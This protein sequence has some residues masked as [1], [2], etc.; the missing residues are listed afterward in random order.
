MRTGLQTHKRV[1]FRETLP[2]F[3]FAL[4]LAVTWYTTWHVTAAI[5]DGDTSSELV[6]SNL[7]SKAHRLLTDDWF[8][9][10]E[11]RVVN[12]EWIYAPLFLIFS[13]WH[14]VRFV[15]AIILQALLILSYAFLWRQTGGSRR[16][17]FWSA[18]LMTLPYSVAHGRFMLYHC[19]YTPHAILSFIV[20]GLALSALRVMESSS[21]RR[22][23]WRIALMCAVSCVAG[24]NGVRPLMILCAPMLA[25]GLVFV[26]RAEALNAQPKDAL[27]NWKPLLLAL[28]ASLFTCAGFYVNATILSGR[29]TF[30]SYASTG[31]KL[32]SV[33][34][35]REILR[36]FLYQFG[37]QECGAIF[38]ATGIVM[39]C[40]LAAALY[41]VVRGAK[42]VLS[43][44]PARNDR[45]LILRMFFP[46]ALAAETLI[47]LFLEGDYY[48]VIYYL[49]VSLWCIP[50]LGCCIDEMDAHFS[51]RNLL[52]VAVCAALAL[53][54]VRSTLF[55]LKPDDYPLEYVGLE[56]EYVHIVQDLED[57]T[58]FLQEEGY[59]LGYASFWHSS[60][61]TE[62]TDG[63]IAMVNVRYDGLSAMDY[64]D[65]LSVR[66][67][68]DADYVLEQKVFLLLTPEEEA[69]FIE[70]DLAQR[71]ELVY[72]DEFFVIYAPESA[73]DVLDSLDSSANLMQL[74]FN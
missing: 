70:S 33:E 49:P 55:Y 29:Y 45:A 35:M 63:S 62:M 64:Y 37:F 21:A 58:E 38:S 56:D 68:R 19:H 24:F 2:I 34:Q 72:G 30:Y 73:Q 51:A 13:D 60:V 66:H 6:L 5:L 61:V 4:C 46:I 42:A 1:S 9:S 48:Y 15:G 47:F 43:G 18:A 11:L 32:A 10:T 26:L 22:A 14:V 44:Q 69:R 52:L 17:F 54:G 28:A 23:G 50:F 39:L 65:W 16:A 20:V 40:G 67:Y 71:C 41:F 12:I 59:T 53:C 31:L 57:A 8:Y 74:L 7:L 36:A 25:T 3:F 27:R